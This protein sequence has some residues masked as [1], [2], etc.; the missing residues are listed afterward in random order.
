MQTAFQDNAFQIVPL[1]FQ[2]QGALPPP[3]VVVETTLRLAGTPAIG[4]SS[5]PVLGG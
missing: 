3:T 4:S 5:V 2:I 1:A